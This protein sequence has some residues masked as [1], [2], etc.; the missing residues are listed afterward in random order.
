MKITVI[1][2]SSTYKQIE[3][4]QALDVTGKVTITSD[5]LD[6]DRA[7]ELAAEFRLAADI[8]EMPKEKVA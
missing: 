4:Q 2:I 8:L 3:I 6:K 5:L 1:P 7:R